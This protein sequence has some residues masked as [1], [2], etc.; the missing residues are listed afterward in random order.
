MKKLRILALKVE[1]VDNFLEMA[2]DNPHPL[3]VHS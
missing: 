1:Q 3:I 2:R